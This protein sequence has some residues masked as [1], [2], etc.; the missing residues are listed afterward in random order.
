MDSVVKEIMSSVEVVNT[1]VWSKNEKKVSFY[2]FK[3]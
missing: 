1:N 2:G 3:L